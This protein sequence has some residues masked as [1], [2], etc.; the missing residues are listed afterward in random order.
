[1]QEGSCWKKDNRKKTENSNY[2]EKFVEKKVSI[3]TA[4]KIGLKSTKISNRVTCG[5]AF[6]ICFFFCQNTPRYQAYAHIAIKIYQ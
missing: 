4:G 3:K 6:L 2:N 1:M 5:K